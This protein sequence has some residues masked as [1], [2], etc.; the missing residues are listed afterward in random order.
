PASLVGMY[1]EVRSFGGHLT[2]GSFSLC[3]GYGSHALDADQYTWDHKDFLMTFSAGNGG[4]GLVCPGTAKNVIAAGGHYQDPFF[5]F[6]G[7]GYYPAGAANSPDAFAPT[8]ALVKAVMLN[9]GDYMT[10][11]GSF[12]ESTSTYGQGMGRLDLSRSLSIKNDTRTP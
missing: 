2:N 1:D 3:S 6:F 8:G 10:C 9:S 7:K 5:D 12:M 4:N 11:C